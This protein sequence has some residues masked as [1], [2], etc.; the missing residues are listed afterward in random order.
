VVGNVDPVKKARNAPRE[1]A[2]H[3]AIIGEQ[4]IDITLMGD[5]EGHTR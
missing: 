4:V 3:Q 2:S 5:F 1:Y